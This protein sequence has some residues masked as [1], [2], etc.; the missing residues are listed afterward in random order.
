MV[1]E[2]PG[3]LR[4]AWSLPL[5]AVTLTERFLA[6]DP[7]DAGELERLRSEIRRRLARVPARGTDELLGI[8]GTVSI[9]L[10]LTGRG[11]RARLREVEALAEHLSHRTAAERERLG[12]EPG[13]ADIVAAGAWVLAEAMRRLGADR[14]RAAEGGLRHG[15]LLELAAGRWPVP[16]PP[17][18][19]S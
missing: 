4:A 7:P 2:P 5:G 1:G 8:G 10:R 13:R 14:L 6:H 19:A 18:G 11:G 12:V 16:E 17:A 15:I 3:T 9:V